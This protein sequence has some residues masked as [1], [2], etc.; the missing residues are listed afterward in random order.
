[1]EGKNSSQASFSIED[2]ITRRILATF[3][4]DANDTEFKENGGGLQIAL[5]GEIR[6]SW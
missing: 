4:S 1:M 5:D 2:E 6:C 3:P